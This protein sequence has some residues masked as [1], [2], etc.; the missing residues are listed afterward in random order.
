MQQLCIAQLLQTQRGSITG[1]IL[2][3]SQSSTSAI[4]CPWKAISNSA[5]SGELHVMISISAASLAAAD[6]VYHAVNIF[7]LSWPCKLLGAAAWQ[8]ARIGRSRVPSVVADDE[9]D[10]CGGP[11]A[12]KSARGQTGERAAACK[13]EEPQ[14]GWEEV[15]KAQLPT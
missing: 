6:V 9:P 13:R 1:S 3:V 12:C 7:Q 14:T 2:P 10:S 4:V 8:S 15:P 5:S 11:P